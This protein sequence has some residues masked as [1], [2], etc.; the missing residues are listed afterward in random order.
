[1][2]KKI[3]CAVLAL[4]LCLSIVAGCKKDPPP[5]VSGP[6]ITDLKYSSA[7][8]FVEGRAAVAN[9]NG[10]WGFIDTEGNVTAALQNY[11]VKDYSEG[12]AIVQK[13]IGDNIYSGMIDKDGNFLTFKDES[14]QTLTGVEG[15]ENY[16][17]TEINNF[18][19]GY[20][21]VKYNN[22]WKVIDTTGTVILS[23]VDYNDNT[24]S[25]DNIYPFEKFGDKVV[26]KAKITMSKGTDPFGVFGYIDE[27]GKVII[28]FK[29][30]AFT[31]VSEGYITA[32]RKLNDSG[33]PLAA[34]AY[35]YVIIDVSN[36]DDNFEAEE[37]VGSEKYSRIDPYKDGY[38]F[39]VKNKRYTLLDANED[40][41]EAFTLANFND[42]RNTDGNY[43]GVRYYSTTG[44]TD[45]AKDENGEE[46]INPDTN[47]PF[48]IRNVL[49]WAVLNVADYS[50]ENPN[51]PSDSTVISEDD[52]IFYSIGAFNNGQAVAAINYYILQETQKIGND[53]FYVI[54]EVPAGT[55]GAFEGTGENAGKWFVY[56]YE[57]TALEIVKY[58][59]IDGDGN[60]VV[61]PEYDSLSDFSGK[62]AKVSIS[63]K[64]GLIDSTGKEIIEP[65]YSEIKY[66]TDTYAIV[67]NG[68]KYAIYSI[69]ENKEITSFVYED[70]GT[71]VS[72]GL[73]PIKKDGKWGYIRVNL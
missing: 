65:K 44:I 58:G 12:Y 31:N 47:E 1:M 62:Y 73:L 11:N 33:T 51:R 18:M 29:Y 46:L 39:A 59:I 17:F 15:A 16:P 3:I 25:F 49:R 66:Y 50:L 20:S 26:A 10:E 54:E 71:V 8:S 43:M 68:S 9:E 61:E 35:Y 22:T 7:R 36:I 28:P 32:Q 42:A 30:D 57:Y 48:E 5:L 6:S 72:E 63:S 55:E 24:Y 38:F 53:G 2:F 52:F 27:T 64:Y 60:F 45:T 41:M 40:M 4:A 14:G 34:T 69:A 37:L 19:Y 21:A 70:T 23:S 67:S 13:K 56:V